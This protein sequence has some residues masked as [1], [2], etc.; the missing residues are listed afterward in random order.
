MDVDGATDNFNGMDGTSLVY[1][2]SSSVFSECSM[3][4]NLCMIIGLYSALYIC[5]D[6]IKSL[7]NCKN[8]IVQ[9]EL[10]ASFL[11]HYFI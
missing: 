11:S 8:G 10:C 3:E 6:E 7:D 1:Y 9:L 5:M 2:C 4:C